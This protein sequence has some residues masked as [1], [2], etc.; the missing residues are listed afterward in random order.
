MKLTIFGATGK[1]GHHLT[2]QALEQGHTVTAFARNPDAI[3][4]SHENLHI[5]QGNVM[6]ADAVKQAVTGQDAI[7]CALGMPLM[8]KA[9]LRAKGTKNIVHAMSDA[10]I[11]RL[12]CLSVFGANDSRDLLTF[13]YKA[14]IVP[15]ILRR[16]IADHE[17]Q[18]NSVTNSTLDWTLVR[19]GNFTK[20]GYTGTYR[21]G[22]TTADKP[23]QIKIS[24]PDLADF[25]LKQLTSDTYLRKA[26]CIS[27]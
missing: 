22:F 7:I 9:G 26:P 23:S 3:S 8:N 19:P 6:N 1:V 13:K 27:Y 21:H 10:G 20:G 5:I 2:T 16:V 24:Q 14:L 4:L 11:K 18:E 25:M 12:V 17:I 15:L